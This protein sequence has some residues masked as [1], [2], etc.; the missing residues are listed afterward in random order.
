MAAFGETTMIRVPIDPPGLRKKLE[1]QRVKGVWVGRKGDS[2]A[3]IVLTSQGIVTGKS[4]RRLASE[5]RYQPE[6]AK[7][8][9]AKVSDPV[10]SQTKL[11]KLLPVSVPIRLEGESEAEQPATE[12]AAAASDPMVDEAAH[13]GGPL[14]C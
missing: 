4:V 9:T 2:D 1:Q 13:L 3:N 7:L 10:M 12:A 6:V 5:L 11:L 14:G 8:I